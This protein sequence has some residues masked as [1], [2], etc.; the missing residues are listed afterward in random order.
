M[1]ATPYSKYFETQVQ[2]A[3]PE[4][5]TLMLYDGVLRFARQAQAHIEEGRPSEAHHALMRAQDILAELMSALDM[6]AGQISRGLYALYE[7]ANYQLV[8][9]NVHKTLQPIKEV[10]YIMT[11]LRD[12]WAEAVRQVRVGAARVG[13]E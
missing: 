2:T 7:Y 5:L 1:I 12:T 3:P 6:S 11:E 8:E 10:L 4:N 13:G 9:A